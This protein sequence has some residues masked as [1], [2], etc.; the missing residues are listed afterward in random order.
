MLSPSLPAYRR[1]PL[2]RGFTLIELL[3][4][5]AI[6][7]IL[8]G[9]LLPAV[10]KVREAAA[11]AKCSNNLKQLG[12]A[13]HAYH[14]VNNGFPYNYQLVGLNSWEALSANYFILPYIEQGNL[15]NQFQ[16]PTSTAP[17]GLTPG[18]QIP[19]STATV[20]GNASN[21]SFDYNGPMNVSVSTFICPSSPPAPS[22]GSNPNGWDG[23]GCNYGWS[24]GSSVETVWG[25][26][27]FNGIIAYQIKRK[28]ADVVDGLS[29]TMLASEFLSGS[30]SGGSSGKYPYDIFYTSNGLFNS[31]AN[32]DFP[33]QT[34]LTN[35]GNAAKT[36][37]SGFRSNDG[38]MWAW[39]ASSQSTLNTATTPNWSYPS[40][41]GDCCPGGAHD[42]GYGLIPP[43]SMHSG[44]VNALLGDGSVRFIPN[45]VDLYTFQ[46]LGNRNDGQPLPN[47]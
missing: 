20:A 17:P 40:A 4:V 39:Y 27:R 33:T 47:F 16:V 3:V 35:I 30:N 41:G 8:I 11:R 13:M 5:I 31:I 43:R 29:N 23:P 10:Q 38:T 45:S 15:F 28:M 21:W 9:L 22:R 2:R 46:L 1:Q 44:G 6:I 7:A 24:T 18:S 36:S 34:E 25:A 12:I 26:T 42:W 19:N 14:D 32:K 37:P